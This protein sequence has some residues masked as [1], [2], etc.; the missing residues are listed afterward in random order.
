MKA[1]VK[2][3][4]G[5]DKM[6]FLERTE[7][8]ATQNFV[9]IKVKY[10]GICGSDIHTFKGEYKN[11]VT[12]VTLG[13]EFS[14]EV[15]EVGAAVTKVAIGDRVTSETTF[16]TCG[17]CR[18]CQNKEYNLCDKRKGIGTQ[19]DGSMS[20]YVLS[21]EASCHLLPK[22]VSYQAAALTE[23][24]ACCVHAVM[25][26]TVVSA[27]DIVLVIGPGPIGLLTV[28][29]AKAQGATVYLAGITKDQDRLILGATLGVNHVIDTQKEDLA[30]FIL[31]KT[32]G[33]GVDKVFDCSGSI[34]AVNQSLR[35]TSKKGVFIQVGLFPEAWVNL[36]VESIIQREISYIGSRSQ[37]PSSW[38]TAL[39]LLAAEKIN[40]DCLIS[41]VYPLSEWR[42]AFKAVMSGNEIKVLL[43]S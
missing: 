29:V 14:G 24:L 35:L 36:D 27:K 5:Y 1:V 17:I 10:T 13:H 18:Y 30:T 19:I 9:K 21:P 41:K 6:Q 26:K 39:A 22:T 42:Q 31:T 37:K 3:A 8:E 34:Q 43:E 15:V 2:T 20:D 32:A 33:Y 38:Q 25:E 11:P 12:P 40:C 7:P 28:Q 16:I 23:P 4:V